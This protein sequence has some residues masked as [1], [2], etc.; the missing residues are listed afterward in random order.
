MRI[1]GEFDILL[2]VYDTRQKHYNYVPLEQI[3]TRIK[4]IMYNMIGTSDSKYA[5]LTVN[6][7]GVSRA[8]N[9][10]HYIEPQNTRFMS[11]QVCVDVA[12]K[13]ALTTKDKIFLYNDAG[14]LLD[15]S[16]L[17][18]TTHYA[19]DKTRVQLGKLVV[20]G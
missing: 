15:V 6:G 2:Q 14:K 12:F 19:G 20:R 5:V 1:Q 16:H 4:Q 8:Y 11:L 13:L 18:T 17:L 7:Q 9:R 10:N 3:T